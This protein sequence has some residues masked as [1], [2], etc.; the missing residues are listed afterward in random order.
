MNYLLFAPALQGGQD[1]LS[2]PT[3]P[4]VH[5][6]AAFRRQ[7]RKATPRLDHRASH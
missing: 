6:S 1:L 3:G 4:P 2:G 7:E 5:R